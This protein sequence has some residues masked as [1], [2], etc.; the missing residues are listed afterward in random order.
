[1]ITMKQ[2]SFCPGINSASSSSI[3]RGIMISE[4]PQT[5]APKP[6]LFEMLL[7]KRCKKIVASGRS[8]GLIVQLELR[9]D[10]ACPVTHEKAVLRVTDELL[11]NA[12]EHGF[13]RQQRGR[14]FVHV[15]SRAQL[16]VQV[17]VSDD[18][19]GFDKGPVID[20]NGFRLLRQIGDL[21]FR[22]PRG[23]FVAKTAITVIMPI[24]QR[25][26]CSTLRSGLV[27]QAAPRG[28]N[29]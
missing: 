15:V 19:W 4:Y 23:P 12:M 22:A 13:Y 20:G 25:E 24:E 21:C 16:D 14:T 1:M 11:S 5:P 10:G 8:G 29:L 9:F 6:A 28:P 26:Q 27:A 3:L 18:G 2:F 7:L 17:S